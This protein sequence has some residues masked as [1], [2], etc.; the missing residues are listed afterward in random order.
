MHIGYCIGCYGDDEYVFSA[1]LTTSKEKMREV[2]KRDNPIGG[3]PLTQDELRMLRGDLIEGV[4]IGWSS[5]LSFYVEGMNLPA[6][7]FSW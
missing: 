6:G 4:E 3:D 2:L 5:S 7:D 1:P